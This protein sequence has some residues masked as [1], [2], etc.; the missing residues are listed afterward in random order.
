[1]ARRLF[2][3]QSILPATKAQIHFCSLGSGAVDFVGCMVMSS[4]PLPP[5]EP[6]CLLSGCEPFS[7]C[8]F[9][10]LL[11][12]LL[13]P[14]VLV[15]VPVQKDWGTGKTPGFREGEVP[16]SGLTHGCRGVGWN[17]GAAVSCVQRRQFNE[18]DSGGMCR[19]I[20]RF[21][22]GFLSVLSLAVHLSILHLFF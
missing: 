6:C 2:L 12:R 18:S 14:Q 22:D 17:C 1:M 11:V 16:D 7:A 19:E 21:L 5:R 15:D 10:L 4:L 8:C 20:Q 9:L 3:N 13:Q